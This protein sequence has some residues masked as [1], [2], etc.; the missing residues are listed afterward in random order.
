MPPVVVTEPPL[1]AV[2]PPLTLMPVD[3]KVLLMMVGPEVVIVTTPNAVPE[4]TAPVNVSP[5]KPLDTPN[6][7]AA[8][9]VRA[10]PKITRALAAEVS[11]TVD[12]A[13]M[14][15]CMPLAPMLIADPPVKVPAKVTLL[16]AVAV[17]PP[18]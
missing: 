3:A 9:L 16:G 2:V 18:L 7:R 12:A 10:P 1:I 5:P 14:T 13:K 8:L 11:R 6:V 15:V 17:K 4:P